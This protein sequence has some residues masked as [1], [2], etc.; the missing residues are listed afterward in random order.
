M[1]WDKGI[2]H[3]RFQQH[4]QGDQQLYKIYTRNVQPARILKDSAE[5]DKHYHPFTDSR[6]V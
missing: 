2:E 6:F 5:K 3:C 1:G 4:G